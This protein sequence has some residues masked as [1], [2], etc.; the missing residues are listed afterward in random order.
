MSM[1]VINR[2]NDSR[3]DELEAAIM[4]LPTIDCPVTHIFTEGLYIRKIFMPAGSL[5]T[6]KIHKL[7]HPYFITE[8]VVSVQ[9]DMG[10]WVE[11]SAPFTGVTQPGTRRVLYVHEDTT[12]STVHLNPDNEKDVD[13]IEERIIEKHE[14]LLIN[15]KQKEAICRG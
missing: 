3:I 9:I 1:E 7:Q 10:E 6:S 14:N 11:L 2:T 15:K 5:I 8:G 13:K 4:D 12:W